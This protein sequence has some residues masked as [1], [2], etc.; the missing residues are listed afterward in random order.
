MDDVAP[1]LQ[2]ASFAICNSPDSNYNHYSPISSDIRISI[3]PSIVC[4]LYRK[5][6]YIYTLPPDLIYR[7]G[8]IMTTTYLPSAELPASPSIDSFDWITSAPEET[9]EA[10]NFHKPSFDAN[11]FDLI[12]FGLVD[13]HSTFGNMDF[14]HEVPQT[15]YIDTNSSV[16]D[17]DPVEGFTDFLQSDL[18]HLLEAKPAEENALANSNF[19]FDFQISADAPAPVIQQEM[20]RYVPFTA[21]SSPPQY[22]YPSPPDP[23]MD[24]PNPY[25][26]SQPYSWGAA[27]TI[28][29]LPHH[30]LGRL[31]P[32]G[33]Q[34]S[35]L[36]TSYLTYGSMGPPLAH[37]LGRKYKPIE[38]IIEKDQSGP[39]D[40]GL[41]L[42]Q[43]DSKRRV[44]K[45]NQLGKPRPNKK[46]RR[47]TIK[48]FLS[49]KAKSQ[50]VSTV[51][52][53]ANDSDGSNLSKLPSFPVRSTQPVRPACKP[54]FI[55]S[56]ANADAKADADESD[57]DTPTN[58]I[59][60]GR[61]QH[62]VSSSFVRAKMD[63]IRAQRRAYFQIP[64]DKSLDP[65]PSNILSYTHVQGRRKNHPGR[66]LRVPQTPEVIARNAARRERYRMSLPSKQRALYDAEKPG[67]VAVIEA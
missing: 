49:E 52:N 62:R 7:T 46:A 20:P 56:N 19:D 28:P 21:Q 59:N 8:R 38:R 22:M 12:D 60:A 2:N 18:S 58:T 39:E 14:L 25:P 40:F 53:E 47:A 51:N 63:N 42:T 33:H 13:R 37:H 5:S 34:A 48:N 29:P 50:E 23:A 17:P 57:I 65:L 9:L 36:N 64:Q 55:E 30:N 3:H 24:T 54:S 35:A 45:S 44:Q 31:T 41:S 26:S 67:V 16:S 61:G 6:L 4:P 32:P 27:P 1:L 11:Q 15:A 66:K 10:S 43:N